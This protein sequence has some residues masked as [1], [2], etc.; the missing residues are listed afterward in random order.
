MALLSLLLF[1][2]LT[3]LQSPAAPP[4]ETAGAFDP[5]ELAAWIDATRAAF[6]TPGVAVAL[7]GPEGTTFLHGSGIRGPS[8]EPV[9]PDTLFAIGSHTK[10]FTTTLVA[11]LAAEGKLSW[12]D[13][14][15]QH[16]PDYRLSDEAASSFCTLRDL[17]CH[18]SG[19]PRTTALWWEGTR[20]RRELVAALA[21]VPLTAELGARW[22]YNNVQYAALGL[23]AEATG[24]ATWEELVRR[25]LFEPLGMTR[26]RFEVRTPG[27][28]DV[29]TGYTVTG[30]ALT[31]VPRRNLDAIGPAGSIEASA[32]DVARWIAL[33]LAGGRAGERQVVPAPALEETYEPQIEI[34]FQGESADLA[35][36]YPGV[37]RLS[38]GLGWFVAEHH[39]LR[40]L[41]HGGGID[42]FASLAG[43]VPERAFGF[44][45]LQSMEMGDS[46]V[47]IA[48]REGLLDRLTGRTDR[49]WGPGDLPQKGQALRLAEDPARR[50]GAGR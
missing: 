20:S 27:L 24:G 12:D 32:R 37:E 5:L 16:L 40:L 49:T 13:P 15:Q 39:G 45:I 41:E 26:A 3:A 22:Q 42:G 4:S 36:A 7:V 46:L 18:R 17:A 43:F 50:A 8:G 2:P 29:C 11:L 21:G 30:E 19:I 1:A 35:L 44:V 48:L 9:T 10:T 31:E 38:Y 33:H 47:G 25:R 14:V 28:A 34:D 6:R 23:A